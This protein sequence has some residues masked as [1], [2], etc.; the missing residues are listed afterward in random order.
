MKNTYP[1]SVF[2]DTTFKLH[3][4]HEELVD[5]INSDLE[6][7][8]WDLNKLTLSHPKLKCERIIEEQIQVQGSKKVIK[9]LY[10]L[11]API[12]ARLES[13]QELI[14]LLCRK[15]I[16]RLSRFSENITD[17]DTIENINFLKVEQ[18]VRETEQ[19]EAFTHNILAGLAWIQANKPYY[20][21]SKNLAVNLLN[22]ELKNYPSREL[23]LPHELFYLDLT[24]GN[25]KIDNLV[26]IGCYCSI[27]ENSLILEFISDSYGD[28]EVDLTMTA[29]RFSVKLN[30]D[31]SL[32]KDLAKINLPA[33]MP[34]PGKKTVKGM[35]NF[36][37]NTILYATM[38]D[39]DT[40]IAYHDPNYQKTLNKLRKH[41]RGSKK[42]NRARQALKDFSCERYFN[43]GGSIKV[44][45][46]LEAA[47]NKADQSTNRSLN[48][49][50][51]VAGHWRN[52][53]CGPSR[54]QIKRVW[55]RPYWKGP[56]YA[57]ITSKP[58]EL[59]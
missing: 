15:T 51:L 33:N 8:H 11:W 21:V 10:S 35:F 55:I 57:P 28:Q 30:E 42:H 1:Y 7:L 39:A 40:V 2:N 26:M 4:I 5:A 54:S 19:F 34:A 18:Y 13:Q 37:V 36:I 14:S 32:D 45:R 23:K 49:R 6:Q 52:Q 3:K 38:T 59:V 17:S 9:V 56:E 27:V 46:S 16:S 50:F 58:H 25:F 43:L 29:L 48:V 12:F 20:K 47:I 24:V 22:T 44:D 31:S 41:P 53:P